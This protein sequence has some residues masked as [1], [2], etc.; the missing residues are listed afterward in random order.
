MRKINLVKCGVPE[1]KEECEKKRERTQDRSTTTEGTS[2]ANRTSIPQNTKIILLNKGFTTD[3]DV[4]TGKTLAFIERK[5]GLR[6]LRADRSPSD[7]M[8]K[9]QT[10]TLIEH[11]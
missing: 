9:Q 4:T 8:T 3:R 1:K 10:A 11:S 2:A 5:K 6:Q 7:L